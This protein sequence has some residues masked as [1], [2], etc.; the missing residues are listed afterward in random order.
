MVL[1]NPGTARPRDSAAPRDPRGGAG[2]AGQSGARA[3]SSPRSPPPAVPPQSCSSSGSTPVPRTGSEPSPQELGRQRLV[4]REA[5]T[6]PSGANPGDSKMTSEHRDVLV[7]LPAQKQLRLAVG[8]RATAR[9]LFQQVCSVLGLREARF[10]GLSVV[11]DNEHVFM[12]LELRLSKYFSEDWERGPRQ[13][14]W[15]PRAPFVT[16]L[17]VQ[18]YV[19]N[20]RV[21]S[22][23]VARHLYYCSLKER[24]LRSQ[25]AHR[26]EAYFLLAALALQA[27][28]G[29]HR[30]PPHVGRYFEPQ[31][32]FPQWVIAKRGVDYI[33]RHV[34]TVHR[35]QQELSP[36]AAVLR[37]IRDA[38]QLEDVPVHFFRL[39]KDKKREHPTFLLGLTLK[40]MHIYQEVSHAPQL[41]HDLPWPC[42]RKLAFLGKKLQ[43][44]PAGLPPSRKLVF[45]TGSPWRSRHLLR[46]LRSSHQ[47]YLSVK[48]RL[49]RLQLLDE[50]EEKKRYQEAY[51]SDPLDLDP[52]L[53]SRHRRDTGPHHHHRLSL[54]SADS[55]GS[56]HTLGT[57]ADSQPA[58]SGEV[59]VDEPVAAEG[60]CRKMPSISF[61]DSGGRKAS[62]SG[63]FTV[64]QV[65]LA[66]TRGQ[67]AEVLHKVREAEPSGREALHSRSLDHT[68]QLQPAPRPAPASHT[69]AFSCALAGLLVPQ[70]ARAALCGKRSMNCLSLDLLREGASLQEFVV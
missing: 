39:Y 7:L 59:S 45:Y 40:G 11:R 27:D 31:A 13:G 26:E 3:A 1:C 58:E 53:A 2:G 67:S 10:F 51:I 60:L 33:L 69:C 38:C 37:F 6:Q 32:Y 29:S 36:Q 44:Q 63:P 50:A 16:S 43:I 4:L 19:E 5:C 9:E 57:E 62:C 34:P 28:L 41:L 64:V 12:D 48:P 66:R 17:R 14:G 30:K 15:R 49:Q 8:V 22:D 46:L 70:E 20:G 68:H 23:Q 21:M 24:V 54:S 55:H 42:I 61:R 47:F 56:A 65:P 18:Y 35:E 52:E 25:C